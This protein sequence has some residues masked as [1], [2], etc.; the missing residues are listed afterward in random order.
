MSQSPPAATIFFILSE[1]HVNVRVSVH[2]SVVVVVA[3]FFPTVF[4][5]PRE[6]KIRLFVCSSIVF[7]FVGK[8]FFFSSRL[9]CHL[10]IVCNLEMGF[11]AL[12]C[13]SLSASVAAVAN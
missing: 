12:R 5:C 6:R 4:C 7:L 11:S 3:A 9:W 1:L 2:G 10:I 13:A 8:F